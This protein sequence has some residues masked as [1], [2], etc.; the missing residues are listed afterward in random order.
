MSGASQIFSG[1][2]AGAGLGATIGS[3]VPGIGTAIGAGVGAI[4][5]GIGGAVAANN[6][7]APP[8]LIAP[9][10]LSQTPTIQKTNTSVIQNQLARNQ[11]AQ[12]TSS[13]LTGGQG[14]LDTPT[15]TSRV[16]IGS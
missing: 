16:L 13:I 7:P 15:T 9:T 5:G 6:T 2:G 8:A 11:N 4:V 1:A 3:I 14:L 12:S 10:A